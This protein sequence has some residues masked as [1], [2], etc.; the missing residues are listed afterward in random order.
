MEAT[1]PEDAEQTIAGRCVIMT[2]D[3]FSRFLAFVVL[4][5]LAIGAVGSAG[6][7]QVDSGFRRLPKIDAHVHI[8]HSGPEF[9]NQ[10]AADNFKVLAIITDHYDLAWQENFIHQQRKLRPQQFA[11]V[12]SFSVKRWDQPDW[13]QMALT[14]LDRAFLRDHAIGVKV[15]KNIGIAFKDKQSRPVMID[16][17]RFDRILDFI[18]AENK[19]LIGHLADPRGSWLPIDQITPTTRQSYYKRHPEYHMYRQKGFPSYDEQI[20]ARDRMLARHPK[21]RVVGAHLA[22][23]EWSLTELAKRLDR[24]PNLAVDTAG[25]IVDLQLLDSD[26]V[27]EFV[28]KYQDRIL[29]AT[30]QGIKPD[31]DSQK[32]VARLHQRW[33]NDWTYLATDSEQ[34]VRGIDHPVRGLKLPTSVLKKIY[35]DNAIKWFPELEGQFSLNR[36]V[37]PLEQ[38]VGRTSMWLSPEEIRRLPMDGKAWERIRKVAFSD[39][40]KADLSD[41]HHKHNTCVLAGALVAVRTDDLRLIAKVKKH[42]LKIPETENGGRTLGLG[43]NLC[44][45]VVAAGLVELNDAGF[46]R[47]LRDVRHEDLANRTLISTHEDRPNN[48]GT[49]AGASRIAIAIYLGDNA[50]L[51]R[52][53]TVFRGFLGDRS[54]HSEFRYGKDQSWQADVSRPIGINPVGATKDGRNIDGVIPDDQRRG[55]SFQWPPGETG[56]P[57]AALNGTVVQAELLHRQGYDA[58]NWSDQAIKRAVTCLERIGWFATGEDEEWLVHLVNTRY[59]TTFKTPQVARFGKS[60]GWTDWT[61]PSPVGPQ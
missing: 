31:S 30:D 13:Q 38:P 39:W 12:T 1:M 27:R 42:L 36:K 2:A 50:D 61:H 53:A 10:A 35:H 34:T 49:H 11:Y 46:E 18:E 40:G 20:A 58:W 55:G 8:R 29:Y 6:A 60:F 4:V 52:A 32:I 57:W 43:R 41:N 24:F 23:L 26:E 25:R 47:W 54:Q 22:S 3:C 21:L 15:W 19:T 37:A 51:E 48:W 28:I 44:A 14:Q 16:D 45:Y 7:Q 9:L 33:V 56:Y 5:Q 59:G 17:P